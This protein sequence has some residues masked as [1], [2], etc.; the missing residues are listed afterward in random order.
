M[1]KYDFL[2][3]GSLNQDIYIFDTMYTLRYHECLNKQRQESH[4]EIIDI[5]CGPKKAS[6]QP[7]HLT[8]LVS[9]KLNQWLKMIKNFYI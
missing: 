3:V 9:L 6:D 5:A 7:G 4:H 8:S 1:R 2:G